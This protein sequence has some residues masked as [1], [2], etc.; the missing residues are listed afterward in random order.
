MH[1]LEMLELEWHSQTRN[2]DLTVYFL[3]LVP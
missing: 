3:G 2:I 1:R